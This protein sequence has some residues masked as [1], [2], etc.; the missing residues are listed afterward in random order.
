MYDF[1][2]FEQKK[3]Q[4]IKH[5]KQDLASLRTGRATVTLLDPV[6]VEAY[7]TYMK[8][9]ELASVSAPDATLLVVEPWDKGL[10]EAI[11]KAIASAGLNLN[12]VVQDNIIR[13]AVPPLTEEKRKEMVRSLHQKVES[14]RVMLRNLR[15]EIKKQIE[16]QQDQTGVSEDDVKADLDELEERMKQVLNE[17]DQLAQAK[18]A[19]LMRV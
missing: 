19:E 9:N 16:E 13:I 5:L 4:I 6:Q 7:G 8:V 12:P 2:L 10:L 18:E 3:A 11:E 1:K 15:N 17:F 14:A